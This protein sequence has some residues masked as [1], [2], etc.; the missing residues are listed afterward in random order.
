MAAT[1]AALALSYFAPAGFG[2]LFYVAGYYAGNALF[3]KPTKVEGARLTDLKITSSGPGVGIPKIFGTVRIAGNR[4]WTSEVREIKHKKKSG[5]GMG[6]NKTITTEYTYEVDFAISLGEGP[7]T[8]ISQIYANDELIYDI[9]N[10]NEGYIGD[11]DAKFK[12]YKGTENQLP[13]PTIEAVKGVGKTPAYRGTAYIVFTNFNLSKFN[14]QLPNLTF[15]VINSDSSVELT[16]TSRNDF[17]L[18]DYN[19][20]GAGEKGVYYNSVNKSIIAVTSDFRGLV[21]INPFSNV[22]EAKTYNSSYYLFNID[23]NGDAYHPSQ[24][25]FT[26]DGNLIVAGSLSGERGVFVFDGD[27]LSLLNFYKKSDYEK[28][29]NIE[30]FFIPP[31]FI[32][33]SLMSTYFG[34]YSNINDDYKRKIL[35]L[36]NSFLM[37]PTGFLQIE[38]ERNTGRKNNSIAPNGGN[39]IW[40]LDQSTKNAYF[41]SYQNYESNDENEKRYIGLSRINLESSILEEEYVDLIADNK[42]GL[43]YIVDMFFDE[44]TRNIILIYSFNNK[45]NVMRY[46]VDTN[47]KSYDKE[48]DLNSTI[49][50][51]T[52]DIDSRSIYIYY[53]S[54]SDG[55]P[56]VKFDFDLS[57][58]E[59]IY[60][61]HKAYIN[62]NYNNNLSYMPELSTLFYAGS[63][64]NAVDGPILLRNVGKRLKDGTMN[65]SNVVTSIATSSGLTVDD[66]DVTSLSNDIVRGFVIANT[67]EIRS[68]LEQLA[69]AFNFDIV[70]TGYKIKFIKRGKNTISKVINRDELGAM[71][72]SQSPE[73][74]TIFERN[75]T[76]ELE[77]P[78]LINI[79]YYDVDNDYN[80]NTQESKREVVDTEQLITIDLPLV[81]TK[82]EAKEIVQRIMYSSWAERDTYNFKTTYDY[83]ELEPCDIIQV[84]DNNA[85]YTM[86]ITSK[87]D[88]QGI[89]SFTAVSQ[90]STTYDQQGVR[91]A[92]RNYR[93]QTVT[94]VSTTKTYFLDIPIVQNSD[95]NAGFYVGA[96]AQSSSMKWDGSILFTDT[97]QN[98]DYDKSIKSFDQNVTA[99]F[100]KKLGDF[101]GGNVFDYDNQLIVNM[102]IGT[103]VSVTEDKILNY[104]NIAVVG[105]ELIQ[106]KNAELIADKQW[107]LTGLL[108]GRWGTEE[109]ISTHT[110]G[111]RFVLMDINSIERA[112][113]DQSIINQNM[114]YKNATYSLYVQDT[115]PIPF[116]NTA[117]GLKPYPVDDVQSNRDG[118]GNIN[119]SW[120]PRVR[121]NGILM[122][123]NDV[124]DLDSDSYDLEF[125]NSNNN[126]VRTVNVSSKNFTYT[127]SMQNA[128]F[129]SLQSSVTMKIFKRNAIIGRGK[130]KNYVA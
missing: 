97:D 35:I 106:F 126:I 22:I 11:L 93:K 49:I 44:T 31:K 61:D 122:D 86:K 68:V 34:L 58:Y 84:V 129:G 123:Y 70:E 30:R 38:L 77:L 101:A 78:K 10:T 23:Q 48:I 89:L 2:S 118:S 20:R 90:D 36:Q 27:S 82:D 112:I 64:G 92:V 43:L 67:T 45:I 24:I 105:N 80:Q 91:G 104:S 98:G 69:Q 21:R 116:T 96:S 54:D 39:S 81:L 79:N 8:D 72:F 13:D 5:K 108:R 117:N 1:A 56:Y 17:N 9:S 60:I 74:G 41:L 18:N 83:I 111:E 6:G 29:S 14:N 110:D 57:T 100:A 51:W 7:I 50:S 107:K 12:I 62:S 121:G 130:V 53:N 76:A 55:N 114:F 119:I 40:T 102:N 75:R 25:S 19:F 3:G 63:S 15:K 28:I 26:Y 52:Y 37:I 32:Y 4:F 120:K 85:V 88:A 94:T 125:Y 33:S 128:D 16:Q 87:D 115:A 109:Y 42:D 95:N 65:L 99:G 113:T 127:A 47:V 73:Y 71:T 46:N 66:I 59:I 103:L 124:Y